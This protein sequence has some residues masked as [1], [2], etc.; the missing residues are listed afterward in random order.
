V[1]NWHKLLLL[2]GALGAGLGAWAYSKG[3]AFNPMYIISWPLHV[4]GVAAAPATTPATPRAII[5]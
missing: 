5:L 4:A 3:Y 2:Y 1:K